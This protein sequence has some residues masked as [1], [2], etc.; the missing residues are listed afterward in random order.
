MTTAQRTRQ[1][2]IALHR[3]SSGTIIKSRGDP[4]YIRVL[5]KVRQLPLRCLIEVHLSG[6]E[7][8]TLCLSQMG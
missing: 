5:S 6:R 4:W 8:E 7:D 2:R 1:F 3:I